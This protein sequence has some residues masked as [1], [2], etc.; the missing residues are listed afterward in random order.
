LQ[1]DVYTLYFMKILFKYPPVEDV[2]LFVDKAKYYLEVP[3]SVLQPHAQQSQPSLL[4]KQIDLTIVESILPS[5]DN[6]AEEPCTYESL[7]NLCNKQKRD[8]GVQRQA[9]AMLVDILQW[10][11][12]LSVVMNY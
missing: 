6:S 9:I 4:S 2:H 7:S 8:I 12:D 3:N 10:L 5:A 11:I 1:T